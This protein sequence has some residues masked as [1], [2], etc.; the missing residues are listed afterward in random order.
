[1]HTT[2]ATLDNVHSDCWAPSRISPLGG[3]RYFLSI[4]DDYSRMTWVFMMKHKS[5]AFKFFKHLT[6]LMMN[7]TRKKV[8]HLRVDNGLESCFEECNG[9]YREQGM[10][11]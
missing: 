6:I 4:I 9:F 5:E 8:K 1:M 3:Q 11:R 7:Q 10:T 2:K